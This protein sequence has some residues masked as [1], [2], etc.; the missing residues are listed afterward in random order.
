VRAGIDD[1][2]KIPG[3]HNGHRFHYGKGRQ[4]D[5]RASL[6]SFLGSFLP[7]RFF[8]EMLEKPGGKKCS[9]RW[10]WVRFA[11]MYSGSG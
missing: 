11:K 5:S 7:G 4:G 6:G 1:L 9:I 3:L 8:R 2:R 10:N